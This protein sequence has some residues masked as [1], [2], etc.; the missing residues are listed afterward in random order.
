[1]HLFLVALVFSTVECVEGYDF[2]HH[3]LVKAQSIRRAVE[4]PPGRRAEISDGER[5]KGPAKV[6]RQRKQQS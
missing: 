2:L 6:V 3:P 5:E 1:M 4:A